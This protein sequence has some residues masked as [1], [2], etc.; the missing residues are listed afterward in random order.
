MTRQ[1]LDTLKRPELMRLARDAGIAG[2]NRMSRAELIDALKNQVRAGEGRAAAE[3]PPE[4]PEIRGLDRPAATPVAELRYE[5]PPLPGPYGETRITLMVRDPYWLHAYWEIASPQREDLTRA[6]G[7]WDQVSLALRVYQ[8]PDG[9]RGRDEEGRYFDV[10]INPWSESWY[11]YVGEPGR[12]FRVEL[13]VMRAQGF[14]PIARSNT[15]STPRDA[16]SQTV[17]E[18]WMVVDEHF[19]KLYRLAGMPGGASEA[20]LEGFVSRLERESRMGSGAVSSISSPGGRQA[21]GRQFWLVL[22]TELIVYGAT[23][24]GAHVTIQGDLIKL[25][26]DGTFALRMALPDGCRRLP[27]TATSPDGVE[28]ITITP[29]VTKQTV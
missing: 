5:E 3:S 20:L 12:R 26:P 27:V 25:R 24:P 7:S 18:E 1:Q 6:F 4:T 21:P 17:D 23:Q 22:N 15:V 13:G 29:V 9:S 8:V 19:R 14:T 10:S 16:V 28:S 2:R 11:I